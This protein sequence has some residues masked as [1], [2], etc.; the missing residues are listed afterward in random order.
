MLNI[1]QFEHL[2]GKSIDVKKSLILQL[3]SLLSV[4]FKLLRDFPKQMSE[5]LNPVFSHDSLGTLI[6]EFFPLKIFFFSRHLPP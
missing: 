1:S 5:A 4:D 2:S 6:L 3:F